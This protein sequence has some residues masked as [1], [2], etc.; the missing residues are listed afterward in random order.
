[1]V[2]VGEGRLE[3]G[4]RGDD[5]GAGGGGG[6]GGGGTA[7]SSRLEREESS[8]SLT[9]SWR[10]RLELDLEVCFFGIE[11]EGVLLR[12]VMDDPFPSAFILAV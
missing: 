8:A 9:L 3:D 6:G 1:M 2:T 10:F 4:F 7:S 12:F 11:V 5:E